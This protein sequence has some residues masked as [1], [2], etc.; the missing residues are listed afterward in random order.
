M[1][2]DVS[3]IHY[4]VES[5]TIHQK[6]EP[7]PVETAQ[8][9]APEAADVAEAKNANQ[10]A[11]KGNEEPVDREQLEDVVH[12]LQEFVGAL[13]RD[14]EFAVDEE[15]GRNVVKVMDKESGE[16]VRQF[17]SEEVLDLV[18]KLSEA[19]GNLIDAKV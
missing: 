5:G 10:S 14:L 3:N 4:P 19:A 11:V 2:I 12:Q 15:S 13:N 8:P 7:L 1:A 6:K 9:K 18:S 16:L 17:P